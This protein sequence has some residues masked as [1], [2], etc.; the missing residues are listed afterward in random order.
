MKLMNME[1]NGKI[2]VIICMILSIISIFI[3]VYLFHLTKNTWYY[4]IDTGNCVEEKSVIKKVY[5]G[6]QK[7]PGIVLKYI[8]M[9]NGSRICLFRKEG[10]WIDYPKLNNDVLAHIKE[11]EEIAY[12][13][14]EKNKIDDYS[15]AYN[16]KM[17]KK[18]YFLSEKIK[19]IDKIEWILNYVVLF[20]FMI[21]S[22]GMM[23][24]TVYFYKIADT[25]DMY[26]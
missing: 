2:A 10:D 1:K 8:D 9:E 11:G 6:K 16:I 7:E 14:D 20:G 23:Y 4:N 12:L 21:L 18:V 22:L 17:D 13:K 15:L 24:I 5:K 19:K 26:I 25:E 3:V